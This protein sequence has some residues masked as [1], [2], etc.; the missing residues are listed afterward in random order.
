[1][2]D[3][4]RIPFGVA[5]SQGLT[6][7]KLTSTLDSRTNLLHLA[8]I[9][10]KGILIGVDAA[11][12]RIIQESRAQIPYLISTYLKKGCRCGKEEIGLLKDSP[13]TYKSFVF[14]PHIAAQ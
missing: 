8:S 3:F 14:P 10:L 4:S 2:E 11:P 6:T 9:F 5:F 13:G 1:M 12:L 7:P